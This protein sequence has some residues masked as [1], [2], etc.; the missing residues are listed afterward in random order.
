[1]QRDYYLSQKKALEINPRHPLIKELLRR[2]EDN[3]EDASA[4]E[5]ALMMFNTATLRSGYML[6]D[7]VAF[8]DH[9]DAMMRETLGVDKVRSNSLSVN[10]HPRLTFAEFFAIYVSNNIPCLVNILF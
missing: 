6:K 5:M 2:V 4:K 8:A 9:I 10:K 7:T 3:P 1:M